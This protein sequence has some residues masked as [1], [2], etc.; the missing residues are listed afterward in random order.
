MGAPTRLILASASPARL[1]TLRAAGLDPEVIVSGVDEDEVEVFEP[2]EYAL[3]LAQLK[4]VAVAAD[5]PRALVIG[6][7]SVLEFEGEVLGK[8]DD[9]ADATER[10]QRMRGKAGVL[11]TGHC[12]IDTHRE[13]WL[14]R[15]AAT[16]VRFAHLDDDEIDAYV[17]TGEPLRVAG[18]FTLDGL[19][20]AYVSGITGDP[21]NVVGIS[22]PLLRLMFDELGFVWHE[23]WRPANGHS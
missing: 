4:A 5:Q 22:V 13:V 3:K 21:H 14:G 1:A 20:G 17:A 23:F 11:H 16:Q 9:A 12:L 6:C 7:D 19:G 2:A 18:A 15:S 10:W 8:P